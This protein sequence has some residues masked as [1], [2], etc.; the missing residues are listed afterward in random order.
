M[1]CRFCGLE[2]PSLDHLASCPKKNLIWKSPTRNRSNKTKF[3]DTIK[4]EV[5]K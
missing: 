5:K 4:R 2:N 3:Y 1:K